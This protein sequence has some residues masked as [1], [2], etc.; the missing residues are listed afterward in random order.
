MPVA[1]KK[2]QRDTTEVKELGT[3]KALAGKGGKVKFLRKNFKDKSKQVA[4][5]IERKDGA[6]A[7]IP[8]S[9]QVSQLV[10]EAEITMPQLIGLKVIEFDHRDKVDPKTGKPV[11]VAVIAAPQGGGIQEFNTD[12]LQAEALELSAEFL[13]EGLIHLEW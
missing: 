6:S 12:E 1:F 5:I 11:K 8:C 7:V 4:L 13:P 2:Y 3:V 10:R 9:A